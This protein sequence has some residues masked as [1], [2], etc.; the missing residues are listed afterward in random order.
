MIHSTSLETAETR[1][2]RQE[3]LKHVRSRPEA[4]LKNARKALSCSQGAPSKHKKAAGP[5]PLA[6]GSAFTGRPPSPS[7]IDEVKFVVCNSIPAF[8]S[9]SAKYS[10]ASHNEAAI[11]TRAVA[12]GSVTSPPIRFK[13]SSTQALEAAGVSIPWAGSNT[14]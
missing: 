8:H 13:T 6:E 14:T 1:R 11:K 2:L 12:G 5:P 9:A 7:L 3:F 10:H 4:V